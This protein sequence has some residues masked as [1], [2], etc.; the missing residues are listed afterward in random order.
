[1]RNRE[2]Y[3]WPEDGIFEGDLVGPFIFTAAG[4]GQPLLPLEE[5]PVCGRCHTGHVNAWIALDDTRTSK[6]LPTRIQAVCE[7]CKL[8]EQAAR[9]EQEAADL[10]T[11]AAG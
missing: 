10:R 6:G 8:L 4:F 3:D 11:K 2:V 7:A 5:R 1:M 9:L